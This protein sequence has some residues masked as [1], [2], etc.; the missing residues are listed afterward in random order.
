MLVLVSPCEKDVGETICSLSFA[1]R[2]RGIESNRELPDVCFSNLF[3]SVGIF[4]SIFV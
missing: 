4:V 3:W 1:K 2:A